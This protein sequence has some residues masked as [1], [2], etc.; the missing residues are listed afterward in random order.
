MFWEFMQQHQISQA[1]WTAQDARHA[2]DGAQT[3]ARYLKDRIQDLE[4]TVERLSLATLALAEILRDRVNV[5]EAEIDAKIQEIDL[6]DG[7]L[8][9][10]LRGSGQD[11]PQC[12]R[13]NA[14][15]RRACLYCGESLPGDSYLFAPPASGSGHV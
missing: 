10:R 15:R 7:K 2:A 4:R 9:G 1:N 13:P 8:D 3:E 12:H 6:R 11:C 14:S 5:T